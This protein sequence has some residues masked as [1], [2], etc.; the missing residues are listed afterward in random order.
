MKRLWPKYKF[1][2][3]LGPLFCLLSFGISSTAQTP[4]KQFITSEYDNDLYLTYNNKKKFPDVIK[5]QVLIALS[6]YP[7]LE[8]RHIAFRFRKRTTPLSSRPRLFSL[9]KKKKNRRYVITI[10]TKTISRL[11]PILFANLPYNAQIGVLGHEIG[12]VFEYNQK[13]NLQIM[14]LA[15]K[16]L[17]S[18]YVNGFEFNTDRI[19]IEHGLGHQLYDW[20][21]YVLKALNIEEWKGA[22]NTSS[23]D[24]R[25]MNPETI[26][27]EIKNY[28]IYNKIE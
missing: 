23:T 9:F 17:N 3:F 10:S 19:V 22:S 6:F 16:L 14:G 18:N 12:H 4:V 11:D 25:Y 27:K 21:S 26:K 24:Q 28:S 8:N 7:E 15:F 1:F 5:K 13:T 20:S 2:R